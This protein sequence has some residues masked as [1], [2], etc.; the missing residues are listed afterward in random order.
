MLQYF[1][2]TAGSA[3][4]CMFDTGLGDINVVDIPADDPEPSYLLV[5][6]DLDSN[7]EVSTS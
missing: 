2:M 3:R 5:V 4:Q 7:K 6:K 1:S